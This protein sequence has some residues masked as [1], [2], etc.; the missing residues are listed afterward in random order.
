MPRRGSIGLLLAALSLPDLASAQSVPGSRQAD[1]HNPFSDRYIDMLPRGL[2]RRGGAPS[3]SSGS[4]GGGAVINFGGYYPGWYGGW[5]YSGYP[6]DPYGY[7]GYFPPYYLDPGYGQPLGPYVLPPATL[8]AETLYGPQRQWQFLG[9]PQTQPSRTVIIAPPSADGLADRARVQPTNAEARARAGRFLDAGDE[10]FGNQR[11]YESLQRYKQAAQAAFDLADCYFRQGQA[12]I[13]LGKYD[14]AAKAFRRGLEL[15]PAWP[16]SGFRLDGL[17]GQ[18]HAAQEAHLDA[19][20]KAAEDSP[21]DSDLLFLVGVQLYFGGQPDRSQQF[22][23]RAA[24]LAG[25][26]SQH[27]DGFLQRLAE[28][29][30]GALSRQAKQRG[31]G[32]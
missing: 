26:Q 7:P 4:S 28:R 32:L 19:L 23:L 18:N 31:S 9:V 3:G 17:Y 13:A 29:Q 24:T 30:L 1:R 21:R 10:Q 27:I 8:P 22:F 25:P 20:A 16:R 11:Y 5:G 14:Q 6:Y 15:D 12:M 2:E